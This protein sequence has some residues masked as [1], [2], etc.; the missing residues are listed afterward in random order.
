MRSHETLSK[1]FDKR[2]EELDRHFDP[3]SWLLSINIGWEGG[4][5]VATCGHHMHLDCLKSYLGSLKGQQRHQSLAPDKGEFLCPLCRQLANSVLPLSPQLGD[6]TQ[7]VKSRP[8]GM[9]QILLE[10]SDL[11]KENKERP[12]CFFFLTNN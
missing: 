3:Q 12:V 6:C 4:V 10:L 8:G 1:E 11:L 9:G 2:V 5:S 7:I